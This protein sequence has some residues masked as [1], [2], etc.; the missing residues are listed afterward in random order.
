MRLPGILPKSS[1]VPN[2]ET[3]QK[4][5]KE[6][7]Q[8][9]SSQMNSNLT[10]PIS[11]KEIKNVIFSMH[12]H[13]SPGPEGMSPIFC[14]NFWEIIKLD[15]IQDIQSFFHSG[16]LLKSINKALIS[17]IPKVDHPIV[18]T[19]FRSISLCNVMYKIISKILVAKMKPLL[20]SCI[21]AY[22]FAFFLGRQILDNVFIAHEYFHF[23]K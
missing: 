9:I 7:P 8:T 19:Q 23:F 16:N 1:P 4:Y 2:R 10:K 11:E 21:S 17:L 13:K 6:S 15:I 14:Q 20:H 3:L 5:L 18:V 22:Q 12:P